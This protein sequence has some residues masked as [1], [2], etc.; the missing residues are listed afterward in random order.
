MR[1]DLTFLLFNND[2]IMY[3][4]LYSLPNST[5][6]IILILGHHKTNACILY[7]YIHYVVCTSS[8][9]SRPT[10]LLVVLPESSIAECW[11]DGILQQDI[12]PGQQPMRNND[13]SIV[14]H[15]CIPVDVLTT[16]ETCSLLNDIVFNYKLA[17]SANN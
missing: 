1:V 2:I 3:Q 12:H 14:I 17:S 15:I 16:S 10:T 11:H 5:Y 13:K 7:Y 9:V 4:S 6:V 8:V